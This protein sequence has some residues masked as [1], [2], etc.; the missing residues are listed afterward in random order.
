MI[1]KS[2]LNL[3][4]KLN[5]FFAKLNNYFLFFSLENNDDCLTS[6]FIIFYESSI[7]C[8]QIIYELFFKSLWQILIYIKQELK[9]RQRD[10][11]TL[12]S[13][14]MIS[15]NNSASKYYPLICKKKNSSEELSR[16]HFSLLERRN[17]RRRRSNW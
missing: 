11:K 9:Y 17:Q 7:W 6:V 5:F 13:M 10:H 8:M 16:Y 2:R 14:N 12:S 1:L 4:S 15:I 3:I